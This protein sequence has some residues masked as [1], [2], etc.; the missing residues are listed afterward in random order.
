MNVL[1]FWLLVVSQRDW[2]KKMRAPYEFPIVSDFN[3]DFFHFL[4]ALSRLKERIKQQRE[5]RETVTGKKRQVKIFFLNTN[6]SNFV[7]FERMICH[8]FFLILV[9]LSKSITR[10]TQKQTFTFFID[11]KNPRI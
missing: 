3:L 8:F 2:P 5:N 4:D 6:L 10:S 7:Y 9:W 1:I 11:R